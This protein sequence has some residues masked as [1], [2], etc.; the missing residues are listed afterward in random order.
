[1]DSRLKDCECKTAHQFKI[2]QLRE[3]ISLKPTGIP[4]LDY[5]TKFGLNSFSKHSQDIHPINFN[6]PK[7]APKAETDYNYSVSNEMASINKKTLNTNDLIFG[8][9]THLSRQEDKTQHRSLEQKSLAPQH[10]TLNDYDNPFR[11][12][13][14]PHL[15]DTVKS[16]ESQ[17]YHQPQ[18]SGSKDANTQIEQ[19]GK[20]QG[21]AGEVEE[22]SKAAAVVATPSVEKSSPKLSA[23][24]LLSVPFLTQAANKLARN[25]GDPVPA[26]RGRQNLDDPLTGELSQRH[27]SHQQLAGSTE[28][29]LEAHQLDDQYRHLHAH[30]DDHD[31]LADVGLLHDHGEEEEYG[32][33]LPYIP[34]GEE[35]D[36]DQEGDHEQGDEGEMIRLEQNQ[37]YAEEEHDRS[38]AEEEDEEPEY[39]QAFTMTHKQNHLV[40]LPQG[41]ESL[42]EEIRTGNLTGL[43][44]F[45]EH[46]AEGDVTPQ[47]FEE[48]EAV[49]Q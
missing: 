40:Y 25:S 21:S 28:L 46:L 17:D 2:L 18:F 15:M 39:D 19:P 4:T 34:A 31:N 36:H 27:S 33:E 30:D 45:E 9:S 44:N 7:Q 14:N 1:M 20:K 43:D 8:L 11:G 38:P 48:K 26:D 3:K 37:F 24:E 41:A 49:P 12:P 47:D 35:Q 5:E 29:Q 32:G 10:Q 13:N 16:K 22:P 6:A 23:A 42:T